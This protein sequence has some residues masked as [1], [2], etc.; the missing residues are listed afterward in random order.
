MILYVPYLPCGAVRFA[1]AGAV[2]ME[3]ETD[4]LI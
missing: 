3:C 4:S 1:Y 2:P